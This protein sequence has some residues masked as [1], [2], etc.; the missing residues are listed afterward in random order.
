MSNCLSQLTPL[1]INVPGSFQD[2]HLTNV[3]GFH[4]PPLKFMTLFKWRRDIR[5][6]CRQD[7]KKKKD[8]NI[9]TIRQV[10]E[11]FAS[12][13]MPTSTLRDRSC[14]TMPDVSAPPTL[15]LLCGSTCCFP[16]CS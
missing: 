8:I 6:S 9:K 10:D 4:D 2:D 14:I 15:P 7:K 5:R 12:F 1:L 11:Y 3:L 13:D 16:G